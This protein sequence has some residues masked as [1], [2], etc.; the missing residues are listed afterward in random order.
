MKQIPTW[1]DM[2]NLM[3][4]LTGFTVLVGIFLAIYRNLTASLFDKLFMGGTDRTVI[5]FGKMFI[6]TIS[7]FIIIS[8]FN[9]LPYFLCDIFLAKID[10]ESAKLIREIFNDLLQMIGWRFGLILPVIFL[11][12]TVAFDS[13]LNSVLR[14]GGIIKMAII[15]VEIFSTMICL[16]LF[17]FAVEAIH[18]RWINNSPIVFAIIGFILHMIMV[19]VD[20]A[21]YIFPW[22]NKT[23]VL[24]K[25]LSR[26]LSVSLVLYFL[27]IIH[28][29]FFAEKPEVC[30]KY[31]VNFISII[32]ITL[33]LSAVT[34]KVINEN[35]VVDSLTETRSINFRSDLG[36]SEKAE[37]AIGFMVF[38]SVLLILGPILFKIIG[39]HLAEHNPKDGLM[40]LRIFAEQIWQKVPLIIIIILLEWFL[41][42]LTA[43]K[44][45][46]NLLS[47]YDPNYAQARLI[48]IRK[49]EAYF[50]YA[51][52]ENKI[53]C[54]KKKT[55]DDKG[56]VSY[57]PL[58]S[59]FNG[60]C[61]LRNCESEP[62]ICKNAKSLIKSSAIIIDV[63]K[64][65]SFQSEYPAGAKLIPKLGGNEKID[66]WD[67]GK[68]GRDIVEELLSKEGINYNVNTNILIYCKEEIRTEIAAWRLIGLGYSNVYLCGSGCGLKMENED[69]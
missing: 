30:A 29:A 2:A 33:M 34:V 10:D 42:W 66:E 22:T 54:G 46:V 12:Y 55:L 26:V 49:G 5:R 32:L 21:L 68:S 16:P 48:D 57:I 23:D 51:A 67:K 15:L 64:S 28:M 58:E 53:M 59:I 17:G 9:V 31:S 1:E 52:Y 41:L 24:K 63:S 38:F 39:F 69:I 19:L 14:K 7:I 8:L 36:T 61:C 13:K 62:L 50:A 44:G 18:C 27:D 47:E 6:D 60:D 37:N 20:V 40:I 65:S 4:T 25:W 11:S 35:K 43:A 3:T 56:M 45:L